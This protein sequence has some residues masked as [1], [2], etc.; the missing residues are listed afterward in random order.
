MS[1]MNNRTKI[2]IKIINKKKKR[3]IIL[4]K[5]IMK[6]KKKI[7]IIKKM[8]KIIIRRIRPRNQKRENLT[9]KLRVVQRKSKQT[10][11]LKKKKFLKFKHKN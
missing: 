5:T 6:M 1:S 7:M 2:R 9:I 3:E 4:N 11:T 8:M 10:K